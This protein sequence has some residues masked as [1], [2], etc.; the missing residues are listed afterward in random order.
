MTDADVTDADKESTDMDTMDMDMT[1][2]SNTIEKAHVN[3]RIKIL[4]KI[5]RDQ[6]DRFDHERLLTAESDQS[7]GPYCHACFKK[8]KGIQRTVTPNCNTIYGLDNW[9][10]NIRTNVLRTRYKTL[11]QKLRGCCSYDCCCEHCAELT[12]RY[13]IDNNLIDTSL[14]KEINELMS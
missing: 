11:M 5:L 3:R 4:S 13:M 7:G 12:A 10:L 6:R 2:D 14:D 1:I 9:S 8:S